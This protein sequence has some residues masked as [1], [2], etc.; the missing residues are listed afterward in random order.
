[1]KIKE[2]ESKNNP[3]YKWVKRISTGKKTPEEVHYAIIEGQK[4]LDEAAR[5][6]ISIKAVFSTDPE[7]LELDYCSIAYKL[8]LQL[9]KEVSKMTTPGVPLGV[10]ELAPAMSLENT[11]EKSRCVLVLDQVQDP[12]N[13]GTIIRTAEAMGIDAV[14]LLSGTCSYLNSKAIRASMGSIF[15][16]PVFSDLALMESFSTLKDKTFTI[17]SADMEGKSLFGYEFPAKTAL[18][19]GQEGRGIAPEIKKECTDSLAIPMQG[20]VES[21][22]VATSAAICMYEWQ[23]YI[24]NQA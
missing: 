23:K 17:L 1:M 22:N 19:M 14:L 6:K 9:L 15:R 4:L 5:S 24:S 12:G 2:I 13:L 21:L 20:K 10:I 16:V 8:P 3:I 11:L 7:S 18:V